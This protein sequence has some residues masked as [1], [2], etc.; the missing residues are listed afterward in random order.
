MR[1]LSDVLGVAGFR[2]RALQSLAARRM[3]S[4]PIVCFGAG[5]LVY[6]LIRN[7]TYESMPELV[8]PSIGPIHFIYNLRLIQSL[9]F[10]FAVYIPILVLFSN[11]VSG[12]RLRTSISRSEYRQYISVLLP[13]WGVLF[14]ISSPVQW[15]IPHWFA[16]HFLILGILDVSFEISVGYLVRTIL[17]SGYTVWALKYLNNLT[18]AQAFGTFILSWA[19]L[20]ILYLFYRVN[21]P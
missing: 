16:P 13:L 7:W 12:K 9:I 1:F 19:V 5:F 14:I 3:F 15:I 8:Q 2:I 4:R 21:L 20:P 17:I 18:V 11:L 10:L 6:T